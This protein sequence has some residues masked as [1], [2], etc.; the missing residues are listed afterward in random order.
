MLP[1]FPGST[2]LVHSPAVVQPQPG[3]TLLISSVSQPMLV[4]IKVCLMGSPDLAL[5]KSYVGV[6]NATFAPVTPGVA[7]GVE[8]GAG[9]EAGGGAPSARTK[10]V[11]IVINAKPK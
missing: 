10:T 2:F 3:R 11:P 4:K 6:S 8:P 1:V 5:P 7:A 9:A